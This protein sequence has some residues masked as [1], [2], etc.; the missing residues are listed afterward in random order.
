MEKGRG[1]RER[2]KEG[3]KEREGLRERSAR[4]RGSAERER[5]G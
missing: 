3:S 1:Q 2:G 4:C 5:E